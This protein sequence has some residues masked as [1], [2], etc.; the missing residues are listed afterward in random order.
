VAGLDL[1]E[2]IEAGRAATRAEAAKIFGCDP[3]E[4]SMGVADILDAIAIRAAAPLIERAVREQAA[5]ELIAWADKDGDSPLSARR[6][7]L[8]AAAR[9]IG[10]KMTDAEVIDALARGDFVGCHLDDAGRAIPP[11]DRT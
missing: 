4:L 3:G 2:A 7:W 9:K 11:T 8:H 1:T 6:R 10:P 5:Q